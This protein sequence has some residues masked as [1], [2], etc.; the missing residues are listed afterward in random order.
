MSKISNAFLMIKLL[1]NGRVYSVKE[2]SMELGV[3]ERMV[4]YY[5]EQLEMAGYIIES[6][7]GPGGG[8]YINK[9]DIMNIDY[10]NKYD[11]EVLDRVEENIKNTFL[12][13]TSSLFEEPENLL[14]QEVREPA[15]YNAIITAIA[16]GY[17]RLSEISTKVGEN[18]GTC[19]TYLK[20]LIS[21]GLVE[22]ENPYGEANS[23]KSIYKIADN[24]FRFWY[25]F[26][27]ENSS[28]IARGAT[29]LAYS[30]I[31]SHLSE[32]MGL[33]F[34]EICRQYLWKLLLTGECP[35]EFSELGCWWGNDPRTRSQS[36]ID[37]MGE[38]DKNTAL[39]G[40]CKWTNEKVD[41]GVLETLVARSQLFHYHRTY[42]YLFSKSGF[43]KGCTDEAQKIGNVKLVTFEDIMEVL[44]RKS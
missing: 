38:A 43:T 4:R 9:N 6:F 12:N 34:E 13:P 23:K 5:K 27:P 19:S 41:L 25:R 33:V 7:K 21:L 29:D 17:S 22:K 16:T 26:V 20:N 14:K 42:L 35:V 8:Y 11:L 30:R 28:I 18:T 24:L 32:Y 31:E 15:L 44:G 37:I 36:E 3:T 40:E 2:L 10:F 1:S 39:F